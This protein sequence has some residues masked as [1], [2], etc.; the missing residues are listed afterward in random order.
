MPRLLARHGS[1]IEHKICRCC[2]VS[3]V[4]FSSLDFLLD[5][6]ALLS[7]MDF[8]SS[9]VASQLPSERSADARKP[10]DKDRG[11]TGEGPPVQMCQI[12]AGL[13][14]SQI[15]LGRIK[16]TKNV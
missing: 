4:E 7:T 16:R 15:A 13:F 8:L 6:K 1:S 5:A 11:R 12:K 10:V 9:A 14:L 2:V 3:Q